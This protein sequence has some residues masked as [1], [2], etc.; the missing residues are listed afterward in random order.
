MC[1]ER[2]LMWINKR[3]SSSVR[4]LKQVIRILP[5]GPTLTPSQQ[6]LG[7]GE[8]PW[9][10]PVGMRVLAPYRRVW[11]A[12]TGKCGS[13]GSS[14][15]L[16]WYGGSGLVF[17]ALVFDSIRVVLKG[18]Y[19]ARLSLGLERTGFYCGSFFFFFLSMPVAISRLCFFSSKSGLPEANNNKL[20]KKQPRDITTVSF[21]GYKSLGWSAFSPTFR[22]FSCF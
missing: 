21:L 19:L 2:R 10:C 17:S 9:Y 4:T 6:A 22:I 13:L 5:T 15:S 3:Y 20:T 16:F 7:V 14:L 8:V 18:L 11:G 1:E 12:F